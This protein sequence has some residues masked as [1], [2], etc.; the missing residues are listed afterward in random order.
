[1][2]G[3][4]R[5]A[6]PTGWSCVIPGS[7]LARPGMTANTTAWLRQARCCARMTMRRFGRGKLTRRANRFRFSESVSSPKTKN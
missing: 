5:F 3:T 1:M 6:H 4:L 2:V 7:C